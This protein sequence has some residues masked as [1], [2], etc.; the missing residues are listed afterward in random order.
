MTRYAVPHGLA[1]PCATAFL[2]FPFI[3]CLTPPATCYSGDTHTVSYTPARTVHLGAHTPADALINSSGVSV[4]CVAGRMVRAGVCVCVIRWNNE[5][6]SPEQCGRRGVERRERVVKPMRGGCR[7][8][9]MAERTYTWTS[10]LDLPF[11]L[12]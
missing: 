10:P 3:S 11:N 2:L 7:S 1:Q 8:T 12:L 9:L 6:E 4:R 5:S